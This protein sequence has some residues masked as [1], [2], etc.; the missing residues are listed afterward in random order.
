MSEP[1]WQMLGRLWWGLELGS[2]KNAGKRPRMPL[3]PHPTRVQGARGV[4]FNI[5]DLPHE[6]N[7]RRNN[8]CWSQRQ[9]YFLGQWLMKSPGSRLR[10]TVIAT[11]FTAGE[12]RCPSAPMRGVQAATEHTIAGY[13]PTSCWTQRQSL[14]IPVSPTAASP[15]IKT[16]KQGSRGGNTRVSLAP[17]PLL[18]ELKTI[19]WITCSPKR[20]P[21]SRSISRTG[22]TCNV[23]FGEVA[24]NVNP[25]KKIC[26]FSAVFPLSHANYLL[27]RISVLTVP[28]AMLLR[29]SLPV[30]SIQSTNWFC[31]QQDN[32]L[33]LL[34]CW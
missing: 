8:S 1:L 9:Y 24:T 30:E 4:V 6:V 20:V 17:C 26:F 19:P 13:P 11:G 18:Q 32:P 25:N 5:N 15:R 12:A 28:A 10:I 29:N 31:C 27:A 14:D 7:K 23:D 16:G 21:S 3:F 2:G 34:C 33:V 22:G